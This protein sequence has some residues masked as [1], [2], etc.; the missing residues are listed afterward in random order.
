MRIWSFVVAL[1]LV[2]AWLVGPAAP[3]ARASS[4]SAN[5]LD[6]MTRESQSYGI[7]ATYQVQNG[8]ILAGVSDLAAVND[9]T[10]QQL[11]GIANP[12]DIYVGQLLIVP[13]APTGKLTYATSPIVAHSN[14]DGA[15]ALIWPAVGPITTPFGVKGNEWKEGFHMGLDIG[16]SYGS[17]IVAA[18][19]GAVETAALDTEHGYGNEVLINHGGGWETRYAHMSKLVAKPGEQVKQGQIIGY[20]GDT[21][22]ADGPHCHFEVIRNGKWVDPRP[23]LPG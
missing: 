11:N 5:F 2:S 18:A 16:A 4:T 22:F 7:Y 9:A 20:V 14:A 17:P 6:E 1:L 23:M 15:P 3:S 12:A 8:N 21:G 13:D 10:L 19:S